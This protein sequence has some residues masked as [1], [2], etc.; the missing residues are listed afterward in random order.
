M[1]SKIIILTPVYNDWKNLKKL[2]VKINKIFEK[3]IKKNFDLIIVNDCSNDLYDLKRYK[4]KMIKKIYLINLKKNVGSQRAIAIGIKYIDSIYKKKFRTIIIDSDGQ[5]NPQIIQKML[6]IS[7]TRPE[8][9][10]AVNRGQRK[11]E[12][13]FRVFYELY[14]FTI[15]IFY[16]RKIRFGNFSLI[17]SNH[18]KIISRQKELWSAFPPTLSKSVSNLIHITANRERRYSGDSKMNF[19]GLIR[20]AL[21]VFSVLKNKVIF[22][23]TIYLILSF[24]IIYKHSEFYFFIIFSLLVFFNLIIFIFSMGNK[25]NLSKNLSKAKIKSF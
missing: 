13:W 23:S 7:K 16:F 21:R 5:D 8:S 3:K 12:L 14:C 15:K 11:E 9:S 6:S 25:K 22:S 24:L 17:N 18:L 4:L 19:F 2:L 10:I 1:K 20:H